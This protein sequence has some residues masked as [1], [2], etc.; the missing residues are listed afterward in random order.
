MQNKSQKLL[1]PRALRL[2]IRDTIFMAILGVSCIFS[3]VSFWTISE[4]SGIA[5]AI[6][7]SPLIGIAALSWMTKARVSIGETLNARNLHGVVFVDGVD[8]NMEIL[9]GFENEYFFRAFTLQICFLNCSPS[10]VS[11][12]VNSVLIDLSETEDK[13]NLNPE[14]ISKIG[15]Q[16]TK[17][18]TTPKLCLSKP[19]KVKSGIVQLVGDIEV[20]TTFE[21]HGS[22]RKIR[23]IENKKLMITMNNEGGSLK[24]KFEID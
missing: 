8:A 12:E 15:S 9:K 14:S 5:F 10:V 19:I 2:A 17:A 24:Y 16:K 18:F 7:A 22:S 13:W 21:V 6:T 4:K 23:I 11:Y 1:R 3:I 20:D